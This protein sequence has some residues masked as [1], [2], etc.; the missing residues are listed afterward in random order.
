LLFVQR[1]NYNRSISGMAAFFAAHARTFL[2]APPLSALLR[3]YRTSSTEATKR[4]KNIFLFPLEQ[5]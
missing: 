4:Q 2:P 5:M 1:Q 3:A